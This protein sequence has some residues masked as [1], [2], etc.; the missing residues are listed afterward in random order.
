MKDDLDRRGLLR[1]MGWA[2]AGV[3]WSMAGGVAT[4]TLLTADAAPAKAGG[5][6][7]FTFVQVSDSHIGFTKEPNPD[8]RATF[9]ESV[10]LIKAMDVKPDFIIHTGD[11]TQLS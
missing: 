8:A 2:G 11:V 3:V 7:P 4:S 5:V 9:R 6:K 1:C 10:A